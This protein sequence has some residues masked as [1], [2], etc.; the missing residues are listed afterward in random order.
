MKNIEGS[1]TKPLMTF[2]GIVTLGGWLMIFCLGLFV[3]SEPFRDAM[4]EAH[5]DFPNL[6]YAFVTY[7]VTNV[8]LLC[9]LVGL[10]GSVARNIGTAPARHGATQAA[11]HDKESIL[12][13]LLRGFVVYLLFLGGVYVVA[14]SPF[15]NTD[16]NLYARLAG[17]LSVASFLAGYS[18]RSFY[19]KI[20]G[21]ARE[22]TAMKPVDQTQKPA[23]TPQGA[24]VETVN[25]APLALSTNGHS[26]PH[27]R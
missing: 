15:E 24:E 7:T 22:N 9:C 21:F 23:G 6:F 1:H 18:P 19:E 4:G 14:H 13:G 10:L 11:T 26:T 16:P 3:D 20:R 17:A 8:G 5:L 2:I 27:P 12:A 25:P